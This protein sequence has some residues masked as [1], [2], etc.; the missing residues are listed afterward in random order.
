MNC[1][2]ET[3][4]VGLTSVAPIQLIKC[5][6]VAPPRG[7]VT[8][9]LRAEVCVSEFGVRRDHACFLCSQ[10]KY[11][12]GYSNAPWLGGTAWPSSTRTIRRPLV[13]NVYRKAGI[14]V[15]VTGTA[16]ALGQS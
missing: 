9:W 13:F 16:G 6:R 4:T 11:T 3:Y 2:C 7:R 15:T 12:R 14:L 1:T 5:E 10:A 8:A